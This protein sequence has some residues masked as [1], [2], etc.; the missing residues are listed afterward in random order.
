MPYPYCQKNPIVMLHI[1]LHCVSRV[2][3]EKIGSVGRDFFF[4]FFF[5]F[6]ISVTR[7]LSF[8][9]SNLKSLVNGE[10]SNSECSQ[11]CIYKSCKCFFKHIEYTNFSTGRNPVA[12]I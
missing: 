11:N 8:P 6:Y 3:F 10:N 5:F 12:Q 7:C 9:I 1:L 4:F 2:T